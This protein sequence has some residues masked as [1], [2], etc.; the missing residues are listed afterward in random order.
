MTLLARVVKL[1]WPVVGVLNTYIQFVKNL[2]AVIIN[3]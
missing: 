1:E 2:V 3:K